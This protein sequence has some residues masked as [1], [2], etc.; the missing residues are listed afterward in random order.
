MRTSTAV[1][2]RTRA[3]V[4]VLLTLRYARARPSWRPIVR[5]WARTDAF[6][7]GLSRT[8]LADDASINSPYGRARTPRSEVPN[9]RL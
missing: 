5:P 9:R 3:A 2:S 6:T 7:D 1:D 8:R 4:F